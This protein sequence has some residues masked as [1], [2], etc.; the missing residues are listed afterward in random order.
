MIQ[1]VVSK[2]NLHKSTAGQDLAYWLKRPAEERIG[3]VELL[4]KAYY[5]T[6]ARLQR[7]ATIR[8]L[9]DAAG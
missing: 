2:Q 3:A 5:G 4:R 6:S 9:K 8:S 1:R 7:T